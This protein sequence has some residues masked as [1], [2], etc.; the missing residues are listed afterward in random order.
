MGVPN[1]FAWR[2]PM[3]QDTFKHFIRD[4]VNDFLQDNLQW[5]MQ[6]EREFYLQEHGGTKNGTY[7]RN[8]TTPYGH[9]ELNVPRDREGNFRTALF[10]R[11][12]RYSPDLAELVIAMYAAG[13]TDRKI[14]DVMALLLG[15]RYS[16]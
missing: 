10:L 11:Y 15:H 8:L 4:T 1:P 7:P 9:I 5:L 14:S 2:Y 13:V 12:A 3:N 6:L 16:H